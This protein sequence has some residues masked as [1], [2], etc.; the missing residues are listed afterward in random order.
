V[1]FDL[2]WYDDS[3]VPEPSIVEQLP[4]SNFFAVRGKATTTGSAD[5]LTGTLD[6]D[7]WMF[8]R[9]GYWAFA[10][11]SCSSKSHQLVLSR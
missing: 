10:S 5:R 6:G 1:L 11:A 8:A 4:S 2:A 3:G 9:E 7:L